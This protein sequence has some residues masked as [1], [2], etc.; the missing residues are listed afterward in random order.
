LYYGFVVAGVGVLGFLI[1]FSPE[2]EAEAKREFQA[3]VTTNTSANASA[4]AA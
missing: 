2:V 1:R 3:G 4:S